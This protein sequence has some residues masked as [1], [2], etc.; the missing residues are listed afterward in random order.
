[1]FIVS[2]GVGKLYLRP[3]YQRWHARAPESSEEPQALADG[4][5]DTVA[6]TWDLLA[7]AAELTDQGPAEV[8]GRA[9]RKI[10][11]KLS[12]TPR[13][14]GSEAVMQRKWRENREVEE[15]AGEVILDAEKG[16]PLSVRLVGSVGYMR[17]GRRFRMKLSV[18][19]TISAFGVVALVAPADAD[20]VATPE[21]LREVDDRDYLLQGIAPPIRKNADGTAVAPQPAAPEPK[22]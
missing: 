15:L 7:P 17:D 14:N 18:Q 9:G 16:M 2:S 6:A 5:A 11:V 10:L 13:K 19:S 12:P 21:R 4:F 8:A 3:R 20:V 1:M 22:K